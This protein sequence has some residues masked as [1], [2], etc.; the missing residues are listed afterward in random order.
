V[1]TVRG[2]LIYTGFATAI[3]LFIQWLDNVRDW[4]V[5][6]FTAVMFFV[7][8]FFMLR[9]IQRILNAVLKNRG[10]QNRR[11]RGRRAED[12]ERGPAEQPQTTAR[13]DHVRRRRE[14]RRR[15]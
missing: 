1:Q 9:L 10:P 3:F 12:E 7:F 5:L 6:A 13:P 8:T 4:Q 14:R 11:A 15:R 2:N